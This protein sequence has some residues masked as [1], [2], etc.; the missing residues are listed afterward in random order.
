MVWLNVVNRKFHLFYFHWYAPQVFKFAKDQVEKVVWKNAIKRK[1]P[2]C[3]NLLTLCITSE[4][5][6]VTFEFLIF[7]WVAVFKNLNFDRVSCQ[8]PTAILVSILS[9]SKACLLVFQVYVLILI[10]GSYF[11]NISKFL[12]G[13]LLMFYLNSTGLMPV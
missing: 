1:L 6:E 9:F 10:K 7:A 3:R 8:S 2:T 12:Q 13:L 4:I 5:D 11:G